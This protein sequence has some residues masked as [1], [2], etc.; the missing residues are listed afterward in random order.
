MVDLPTPRVLTVT[1][2]TRSI[3]GL[4][5][6]EFPFVTVSGEISNLRKPYSGHLYFTLK[7]DTAQLKM[8][9][10]KTQQ[11][12]LQE[13]P[14]DGQQVICRG[15]IS[16]YE[17]RGEYQLIVDYMER[18]GTGELQIAFDKLKQRLADEGLFDEARKREIPA[19][20]TR[21]GLVT[22]PEGAAVFDF[23]KVA[24]HRFP[25][26]P[27]EIY[28]V[29]VQGDSAVPEICEA[30]TALNQRRSSEVIVLCRGGGSIEDLWSFNDER[31]ARAI[32]D[33][34]IP[35]VSAIG[36]EIDYTIA[37][38]VADLRAPTPTAAA[39]ATVPDRQL[40]LDRIKR[41]KEQLADSVIQ[42][43][44]AKKQFILLQRRILGDPRT[45]L[46]HS[47]L[48][49]D[50]VQSS[51]IHAFKSLLFEKQQQHDT[52]SSRLHKQSPVQQL[53]YKEQWTRELTRRLY[54]VMQNQLDK[55]RARLFTAAS[56]LDAVSPLAVLGRGYAV[57]RSGVHEKPPGELIRSTAQV[58]IGKQLEI[59]LQ[60]GK[61][62]TEVKEIIDDGRDERICSL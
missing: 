57:V 47:L 2:L 56:L 4:L 41:L 58:D 1:E 35:V 13:Q 62:T 48:Y 26:Q 34:E 36:H 50:N 38:F 43:I 61:L 16:V 15:R 46:T 14:A 33:S 49:L 42:D 52:L 27:I 30:I 25:S 51:F 20:P 21:I 39:E 44:N 19:F 5:E 18:L 28:P 55:K 11:R 31:V 10:F 29:R 23:L 54:V 40:L 12:Y 17:P 6:T 60:K 8:V 22:S 3:R 45:V 9:L 32:Y 7:D 53:A 37:D 59:I 24:L